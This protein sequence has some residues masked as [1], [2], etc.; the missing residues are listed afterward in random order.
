[1]KKIISDCPFIDLCQFCNDYFLDI[2]CLHNTN[3]KN[4]FKNCKKIGLCPNLYLCKDAINGKLSRM[5]LFY[6]IIPSLEDIKS[7]K[8]LVKKPLKNFQTRFIPRIEVYGDTFKNQMKIIKKLEVDFIAVSLADFI[9]NIEGEILKDNFRH[10]LHDR[11]DFDGKILLQT[12]IPDYYCIKI[13][14]NHQKYRDALNCLDPDVITTYDTNFY[15]DQPLFI[16]SIQIINLLNAN[17]LI[18][19]I[20]IP[21]IFL[22]PPAP[23]PLFKSIFE[24]FLRSNHKTI[25]LPVAEFSKSK[26]TYLLKILNHINLIRETT[27][28]EFE[29]LLL[30]K[31]PDKRIC[32]DC[33]SS[34]TW[35]KG[36]R[37]KGE[38]FLKKM[39]KNLQKNIKTANKIKFQKTLFSFF[40]KR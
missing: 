4:D 36:K 22:L 38:D 39:E 35:V 28:K 26:N 17:S 19:D 23:L 6:D 11:L 7:Y 40:Y 25:C 1:M 3:S 18:S 32:V 9:S 15:L 10:N 29:L 37:N 31:S 27:D 8:Y 12:N 13:M 30:S 2:C 24:V 16:S 5:S 21:Q 14:E 20:E 33:Y 34:N